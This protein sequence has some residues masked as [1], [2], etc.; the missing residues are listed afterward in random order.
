MKNLAA[1]ATVAILLESSACAAQAA[2][3]ADLPYRFL[4]D[5]LIVTDVDV[6]GQGPFPFILDTAASRTM[7]YEHLRQ[8]LGLQPSSPKLLTVYGIDNVG[9][10]IPVQPNELR[11]AEEKLHGLTM[12]V[13]PDQSEAQDGVLGL[14]VLTRYIVA[15]DRDTMRLKLIA[16][17]N[18]SAAD[19][20]QWPSTEMTRRPLKDTTINFWTVRTSIKGV[21]INTLLDMGAG[22]TLLNWAAAEKLGYKRTNFSS[23]GVPQQLRDALG[24]VEPVGVV[25]DLTIWMG[26]RIFNNQTVIIANA[27]VFRYFGMDELPA[28]I[29]GPGLIGDNSLAIDFARGRLYLGPGVHNARPSETPPL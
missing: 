28:A 20:Q 1:I 17:D 12:G 7:L 18:D 4:S 19:Y 14:D 27:A 23:D 29:A 13:L 3:L 11:L 25:N 26:G 5:R 16:P 10:A 24:T 9:T 21:A 8:R 15:L 22:M 2:V 6:D